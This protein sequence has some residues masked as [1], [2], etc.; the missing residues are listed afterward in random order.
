MVYLISC[1]SCIGH[2]SGGVIVHDLFLKA[3]IS[4]LNIYNNV[5]P[6]GGEDGVVGLIQ[7]SIYIYYYTFIL[8]L[9][10][11][12]SHTPNT[13][14]EGLFAALFVRVLLTLVGTTLRISAGVFIPM[15]TLG[16]IWYKRHICCMEICL[17]DSIRVG[18]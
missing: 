9:L 12:Y 8:F 3:E 14:I 17:K 5:S 7:L 16:K 18:F 15:L 10:L 2:L 11:P 6:I 4:E 13:T 1:I